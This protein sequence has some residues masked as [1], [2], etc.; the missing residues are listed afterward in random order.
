[1]IKRNLPLGEYY[2]ECETCNGEVFDNWKYDE[3]EDS[4]H[5][6]HKLRSMDTR[7]IKEQALDCLDDGCLK[8]ECWGETEMNR[9]KLLDLIKDEVE[10]VE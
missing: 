10:Q 8:Q 4:G 1:L 7:E 9:R 6:G 3:L 2:L 5:K